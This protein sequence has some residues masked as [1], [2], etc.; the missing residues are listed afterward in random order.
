ME[1]NETILEPLTF[2]T[3]ERAD[4]TSMKVLMKYAELIGS[5]MNT[6]DIVNNVKDLYP[7]SYKHIFGPYILSGKPDP[8]VIV[9]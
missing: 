3:I 1:Q 8:D 5:C 9:I 7:F 4:D 2:E 6:T